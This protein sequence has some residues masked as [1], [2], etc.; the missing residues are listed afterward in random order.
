MTP[1]GVPPMP[2][3]RS[4]VERSLTASSAAETSPSR[5]RRMRAPASRIC[6]HRVLVA[7]AVEHDHHHVADVHALALGDQ[8]QRL[9][10]RPVE[11]EQVGDLLAAGELLHVDA[12]AR[13]RTS[14]R[15]RRARSPRA[16]SASRAPS[17]ACPRAGRRR[18]RPAAACRCRSARRCRAS[19]PR[20]SRPRR[21]RRRRPSGRCRARSA[22]R[23]RRPGRR[24]P[25]RRGRPG[26]RRRARPPRSR[27]RARARGCGRAGEL[28]C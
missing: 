2:H 15:A 26:G 9:R 12:R 24:P 20:P 16:R 19:A 1:S 5:I 13:D 25:C 18:C 21:S 17:G 23:R 27:A 8:L 11:D 6:L 10:Q 3:S 28:V 14:S 7:R 4:T 22:S